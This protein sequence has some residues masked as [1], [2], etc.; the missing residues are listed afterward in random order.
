MGE[1]VEGDAELIGEVGTRFGFT[2]ACQ[3]FLG[4]YPADASVIHS[5]LGLQSEIDSAPLELGTAN[6]LCL[7]NWNIAKNNHR[8][9]WQRELGA[10]A[11]THNPQLFFFQEA[12]LD[13]QTPDPLFG[14]GQQLSQDL[15]NNLADLTWHFAPNLVE[16]NRRHG[17]GVLTAAHGGN[18]SHCMIHSEHREPLIATP[19]VALIAEYALSGYGQTLLTINIHG[20]NFVRSHKF[21][22]Q[23]RQIEAAIAHHPGPIIFAGDFNTWRSQRMALLEAS[24][25]RLG[26]NRVSFAKD[27]DRQLKRFLKSGPLDHVFYRGVELVAE[28]TRVIATAESSDHK[29]MVVTFRIEPLKIEPSK[30]E[31]DP[32]EIA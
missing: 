20:I 12:R 23:L 30:I 21:A 6:R 19:K 5:G 24:M 3:I 18:L 32:G 17:F 13:L 22:A 1:R 10:I 31:Q 15:S 28:E 9:D 7:L 25:A 11:L 2:E 29:P 26:L 8:L 14:Q 4:V 27:C 16:A